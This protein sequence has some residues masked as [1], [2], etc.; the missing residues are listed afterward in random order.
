MRRPSFFSR[1]ILPIA[2]VLLAVFVVLGFTYGTGFLTML[3]AGQ[4]RVQYDALPTLSPPQIGTP[5]APFEQVSPALMVA[6]ERLS[7]GY[8]PLSEQFFDLDVQP[9]GAYL[10]RS[11]NRQFALQ[12]PTPLPTPFPYPTS[13][14]LP[15]PSIPNM[16]LPTL[17]PLEDEN[18]RTLPYTYV[19]ID[20]APSGLPVDGILTQRYHRYHPAIDLGVPVGTPVIATHSG[21]VI[22]ADWSTVGYGYLVILQSGAFIT[23]YAHNTSFNVIEGQY[24]GKGSVL[25]W[26][27][28]TGNS[29]GP[30]VHYETRVNDMNVD[31]LTFEQ[32]GFGTC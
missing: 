13:P 22:Y 2:F 29:T 32:R 5:I 18:E 20:C 3:L 17:V 31:P 6:S 9:L 25:A 11:G 8:Q 19:G 21:Q 12:D 28:N 10:P 16:E 30:H 15:A 14:P 4:G 27:G 1:Y 26:S 7:S 24:V 23:Y